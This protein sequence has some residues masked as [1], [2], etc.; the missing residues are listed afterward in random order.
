MKRNGLVQLVLVL[1]IL[2]IIIK[3][4]PPVNDWARGNLPE[5]VLTI[6]GEKPKSIFEK[7]GDFLG[8]GIKKGSDAVDNLVD[9]IAN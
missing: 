7:G 3:F 1:I 9:K 4:V 6:I 8:K 5:P 2:V